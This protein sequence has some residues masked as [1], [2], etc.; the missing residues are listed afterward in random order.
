MCLLASPLTHS[1][2]IAS[3]LSFEV[4]VHPLLPQFPTDHTLL[5]LS[6]GVGEIFS[7]ADD[8]VPV[9]FEGVD[10]AFV[11]ATTAAPCVIEV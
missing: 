8:G 5:L 9:T 10:C 4:L 6:V 11:A 3:Q 2:R 1:L 7:S